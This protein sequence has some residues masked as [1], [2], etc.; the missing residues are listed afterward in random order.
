[1]PETG[2]IHSESGYIPK[3]LFAAGG[4]GGHIYPALAVQKALAVLNGRM[5]CRFICG[6]RPLEIDLYKRSGIKPV[7]L[8]IPS[9][10]AGLI[11]RFTDLFRIFRGFVQA[12]EVLLKWKP[13]WI[14]AQG[15]Y[16]TAPVLMAARI[17]RIPYDIQEQNTIPG[18]TNKW[19]ASGARTI[20]CSFE[21]AVSRFSGIDPAYRCVYS[22]MPLRQEAI[23]PEETDK[24][25]IRQGM[26]L[27]PE[28]P[29]LLVVGGSQG[30][31]N[32]Y[33]H[34]LSAL[35]KMDEDSEVCPSFQCL[36]ST[37]ERN[38][39]WIEKDLAARPFKRIRIQVRSYLDDMGR[40][41]SASDAAVSRSGACSVAEL[42]ANRIPAVFV[43]LPHSKDDHQRYNAQAAVRAGAA[44]LVEEGI[45][46]EKSL[47]HKIAELMSSREKRSKMA[48]AA[49]D[50]M[51]RDAAEK[52]AMDLMKKIKNSC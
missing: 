36:W 48:E 43:P 32:L 44:Y 29:L 4:T 18:R 33:R 26:G 7:V 24:A 13:D 47:V 28:L 35:R 30:A 21:D 1:M 10:Q 20:Y 25:R 46:F 37:G 38:L 5:E 40:V 2:K 39:G 41:Y 17:L 50:L 12:F 3:I 27:E 6:S 52:I 51:S 11:A 49:R 42:T 22:G 34:L 9:R 45:D 15:G 31:T 16:V 19:F 8:D 14:L 23:I